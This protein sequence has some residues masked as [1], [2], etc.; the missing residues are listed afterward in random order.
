M[1]F[2]NLGYHIADSFRGLQKRPFEKYILGGFLV[3]YGLRS[4]NMGRWPRRVLVTAGVYQFFVNWPEYIKLANALAKG[5]E[6]VTALI[7]E[8]TEIV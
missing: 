3:W 2:E 6:G 4:K 7:N 8:D 1:A 5:K